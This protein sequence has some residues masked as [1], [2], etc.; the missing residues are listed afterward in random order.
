MGFSFSFL[1][2]KNDKFWSDSLNNLIKHKP[3]ISGVTKE[4]SKSINNV[5]FLMHFED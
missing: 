3:L 4:I 5:C 2:E 1:F